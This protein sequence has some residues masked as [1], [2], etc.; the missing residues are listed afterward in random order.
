MRTKK[1]RVE[2]ED[3]EEVNQAD[4]TPDLYAFFSISKTATPAEIKKAYHKLCLVYHPDKLATLKTD[5]D[6]LEATK[7]FQELAKF[8]NVLSDVDKK[9]RYDSTGAID[10]TDE[11]RF[12]GMRPPGGW[13][14][15]FKDLW[16]GLVTE[17]SINVFAAKYKGS[18]EEKVDLFEAY[19]TSEGNMDTVL[20]SVPL[21]TYEDE[22]RFRAIVAEAV[23]N[24]DV[25][26]YKKFFTVD[27][28]ATEK[29]EASDLEDLS[30]KMMQKKNDRLG[31]LIE[32]LER[33]EAE[34]NST[35]KGGKGKK[36]MKKA[37]S[38]PSEEEFQKLQDKLFNKEK[39]KENNTEDKGK[40]KKTAPPTEGTR[41]SKRLKPYAKAE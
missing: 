11:A 35:A 4:S 19:K 20:D 12:E 1:Q 24:G 28:A 2:E 18:L 40:R 38:E 34:R 30:A 21:C 5:E 10:D 25:P 6:K 27:K 31:S 33:E 14:K 8:Y 13:D 22:D 29:K 41:S 9:A 7:K 16:G 37:A 15:Y 39:G 17:Q 36:A 3:L 23:K 26:K 32:K